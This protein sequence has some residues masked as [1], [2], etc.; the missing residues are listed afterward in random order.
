MKKT[1]VAPSVLSLDYAHVDVSL[2][3]LMQ[4]EAEW[5][6]FDVMDNH[7]VPNLTFGP[8]ILKGFKKKTKMFMDV[9]LMVEKPENCYKSFQDAGADMINIHF[10]AMENIE[11]CR[12]LLLEIKKD[13]KCG[14]TIKPNTNVRVLAPVLDIVDLVLVMSVEPGFG[15]QIFMPVALD[16]IQ[17]LDAYR[18]DHACSYVIEVDGGIHQETAVLCKQAGVDV[19]V[20]GSYIFRGD[21][22]ERVKS[23]R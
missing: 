12:K 13:T 17:Y 19:L 14:V 10:E 22:I 15:G 9:H 8:D 4:S 5:I 6:H 23:L 20:A 3:V 21:I 18:R 1:I 7:F 11:A 2:E 16:K